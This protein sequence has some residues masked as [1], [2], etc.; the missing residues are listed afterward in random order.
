MIGSLRVGRRGATS[1]IG[2]DHVGEDG[3]RFGDVE[4]SDGRVHLVEI[5]AAAQKF[6]IDRAYLVE[7]VAQFAE[8]GEELADFGVGCIRHVAN[9]R[10]LAGSTDC[11]KISLGAMPRPIDT[12]AVGPAAALV[13]LDQR[14][15]Q[16]LFDRRQAARE[17]VAAF[18]QGCG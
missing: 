12:V 13:G 4:S 5:L 3:A 9:P 16:Y 8:V 7:H 17:P 10:A 2:F 15:A 1:K 11:G 14:A 6:G 18:E